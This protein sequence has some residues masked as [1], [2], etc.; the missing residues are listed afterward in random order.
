MTKTTLSTP[1]AKLIR[2]KSAMPSVPAAAI[3]GRAAT[4]AAR[5]RLVTTSTGRRGHRSTRL[6]AGKARRGNGR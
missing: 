4:K 6:P 5:A 3:N 1:L 2:Y